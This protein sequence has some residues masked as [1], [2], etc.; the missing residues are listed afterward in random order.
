MKRLH[1]LAALCAIG[2]APTYAQNVAQPANQASEP[3]SAES[4][5]RLPDT[6]SEVRAV[7][8]RDVAAPL[9]PLPTLSPPEAAPPLPAAAELAVPESAYKTKAAPEEA[10]EPS[11]GDTLVDAEIGAGLWSAVGAKLS[12]YKPGTITYGIG[13][14]HESADGLA[15]HDAGEGYSMR[16][17]S[18]NG[19]ADGAGS[20]GATWSVSA[21]FADESDGL[22]GQSSDFYAVSH[23]YLDGRTLYSRPLGAFGLRTT[24]DASLATRSL[25]LAAASPDAENGLRELTLNP[26]AG[27][28]W[29]RGRLRLSL[30][31]NYDYRGL[32]ADA[33]SAD[34]ASH[35]VRAD[36]SA[37]FEYSPSLA[38]AAAVGA[39]S[40]SSF[41]FLAPFS[42]SAETALASV[43]S[44]T[45]SGGLAQDRASLAVAWR[46][47][48]YLD[49]GDEIDDDARWFAKTRLELFGPA[50]LTL[51]L[52]AD[53]ASSLSGGGRLVPIAP[54]VGSTRALYS[55]AVEEYETLTTTASVRKR[56]GQPSAGASG[57][58]LGV[59]WTADWLDA[60]VLGPDKRLVVD[61]EY[62]GTGEAYGGQASASFGY[63]SEEV[64]RPIVDV[65]GF[66]RISKSARL[67]LDLRDIVSA[68]V[69]TDGRSMYEPYL[70]AGFRADARIQI[71]L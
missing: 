26:A 50:T 69:G 16:R 32:F 36:L 14:S 63:T 18:V 29:E 44:F 27:L 70:S 60:P 22:Q 57:M 17:S 46:A 68:F 39:A 35:A 47:N 7:S 40:T 20:G 54:P 53:W 24:L 31:G 2:F 52:G 3:P 12:I 15:F 38:F 58:T 11:R 33:A 21:A 10:G 25:E 56:F 59:G 4:A 45:V 51:R 65:G 62:R 67:L 23:R 49:A 64:D 61:L 34:D 9:P 43:A 66:I 30:D 13:F 5:L 1:V 37:R 42:V 71:S 41:V 55:Y 19:R 48:P 8:P 6:E 28:D